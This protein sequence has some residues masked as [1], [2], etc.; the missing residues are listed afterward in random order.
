MKLAVFYYENYR[1]F[2]AD[3]IAENSETK[4]YRTRLAEAAGCQKSFLSQVMAERVHL[5]LDH[6]A[7]IAG[8]LNYDTDQSEYLIDLVTFARAAEGPLKKILYE[9]LYRKKTDKRKISN[10]FPTSHQ[11]EF[12]HHAEF[13]TRW[14]VSAVYMLLGKDQDAGVL[15][16]RLG[17]EA[18]LI[19]DTLE[20][21]ERIGLTYR[22]S[23]GRFQK[24]QTFLFLKE[25]PFKYSF[26]SSWRNVALLKQQL[27]DPEAAFFT[28]LWSV[29]IE[30]RAKILRIFTEAIAAAQ[31][32][33]SAQQPEEDLI[34]LNMDFFSV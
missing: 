10:Q 18:T 8:F 7:A 15:S 21:L 34:C 1:T 9:R 5:T 22:D 2:L 6:A 23:D 27:P 13:Y 30:N 31:E 24:T 3:L 33:C 4:G 25:S 26:R 11:L 28:M 17:I 12:K 14:Y 19:T 20:M 29:S 32:I 16:R